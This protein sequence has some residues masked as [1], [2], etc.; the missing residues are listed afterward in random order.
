MEDR[1]VFLGEVDG[2]RLGFP[3]FAAQRSPEVL[4]FQQDAFVHLLGW[5]AGRSQVRCA[6]V[7]YVKC[8]R[9][10]GGPYMEWDNRRVVSSGR[11]RVSI[12]VERKLDPQW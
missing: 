3:E 10:G 7:T 11:R 12:V 6:S 2:L 5:S 1:G 4:G 8:L 9:I